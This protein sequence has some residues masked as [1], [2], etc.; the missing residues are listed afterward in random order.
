MRITKIEASGIRNY[1]SLNISF[2]KGINALYGRNGSGKT[3]I[4]EIIDYVTIGKSF[5]ADSD[6]ELIN[7]EEEFAKVKIEYD[8][9]QKN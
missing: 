2:N 7:F 4:V 6:E 9:K 5:K 3:N 1:R 8:R